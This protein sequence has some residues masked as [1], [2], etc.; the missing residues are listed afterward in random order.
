MSCPVDGHKLI[1][2]ST[3]T[4]TV[5]IFIKAHVRIMNYA[6]TNY[7]CPIC[8]REF[9]I[10]PNDVMDKRLYDNKA[11]AGMV[12]E[13]YG[14]NHSIGEIERRFNINHG[15]FINIAHDLAEIL[16]P[17]YIFQEREILNS[18]IVQMDETG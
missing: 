17:I 6:T 8:R 2:H 3:S 11:I 7:E 10:M 5:K 12:I 15:T 18:P 1:V 9:K 4:R 14:Y 16:L 13:V